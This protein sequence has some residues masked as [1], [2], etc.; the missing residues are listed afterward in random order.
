MLRFTPQELLVMEE[1]LESLEG[2]EQGTATLPAWSDVEAILFPQ[3]VT[4]NTMEPAVYAYEDK[5]SFHAH[6]LKKQ[7]WPT[8]KRM[9]T[10]FSMR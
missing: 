3:N 5:S 1:W 9:Q 2:S 6:R 10:L 4:P 8:K 7:T